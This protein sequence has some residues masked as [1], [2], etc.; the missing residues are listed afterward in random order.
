MCRIFFIKH[1]IAPLGAK[2][3][4]LAQ[5][6]E[7]QFATLSHIEPKKIKRKVEPLGPT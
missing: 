6:C 7:P 5:I 3:R 2:W 4:N 1:H